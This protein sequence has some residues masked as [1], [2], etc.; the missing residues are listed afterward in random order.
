MLLN[1]THWTGRLLLAVLR[2]CPHEHISRPWR[3]MRSGIDYI[4]CFD[5]AAQLVSPIQ[6]A[7][8]KDTT[9]GTN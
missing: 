5:C 8:R 2:I 7:H 6:F 9:H 3:N 1:I 4:T